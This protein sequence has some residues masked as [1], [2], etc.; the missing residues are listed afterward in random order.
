MC[1]ALQNDKR[2]RKVK[3][4]PYEQFNKLMEEQL[5]EGELSTTCLQFGPFDE[6]DDESNWTDI[7]DEN[8]T[9]VNLSDL[10]EE[11]EAEANVVAVDAGRSPLEEL[12]ENITAVYNPILVGRPSKGNNVS[13]I[14]EMRFEAIQQM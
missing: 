1:C 3:K 10:E 4:I 8:E 5:R 13:K 14:D 6:E 9:I 11:D 7:D 2:V 12:L